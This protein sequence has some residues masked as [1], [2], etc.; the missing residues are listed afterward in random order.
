[1]RLKESGKTSGAWARST[2]RSSPEEKN[3]VNLIYN[4]AQR[5]SVSVNVTATVIEQK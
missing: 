3:I 2:K 5:K 1:M 4:Y